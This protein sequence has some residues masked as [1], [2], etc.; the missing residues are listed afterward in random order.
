M[1]KDEEFDAFTNGGMVRKKVTIALD[2]E[3]GVPDP[4]ENKEEQ[5]ASPI[6]GSMRGQ[7]ATNAGTRS[8]TRSLSNMFNQARE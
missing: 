3:N 5:V 8:L 4:E 1:S 6:Q 2:D 7:S